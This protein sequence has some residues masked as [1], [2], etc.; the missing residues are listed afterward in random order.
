VTPLERRIEC[1]G[2]AIAEAQS[3]LEAI[4]QRPDVCQGAFLT[5]AAKTIHTHASQLQEI[6]VRQF[7]RKGRAK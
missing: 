1:V 6:L 2:M 3:H 5:E 7:L 4:K